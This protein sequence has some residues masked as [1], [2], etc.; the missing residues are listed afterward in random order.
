[1]IDEDTL[2]I[3]D[4]LTWI[5]LP[6][7]CT[8]MYILYINK[9][10]FSLSIHKDTFMF[11]GFEFCI[12]SCIIYFLLVPFCFGLRQSLRMY[13]WLAWN[14]LFLSGGSLIIKICL[15]LPLRCWDERQA[16]LFSLLS[17]KNHA[18]YRLTPY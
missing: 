6:T 14:W 12:I 1:M 17:I 3:S 2:L 10:F 16:I 18:L 7:S 8:Y 9:N 15:L 5:W 11:E 4:I 13:L